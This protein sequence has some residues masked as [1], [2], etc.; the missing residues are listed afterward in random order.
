[1]LKET[2][3]YNKSG[4]KKKKERKK[5]EYVHVRKMVVFHCDEFFTSIFVV[6]CC[7]CFYN[8]KYGGNFARPVE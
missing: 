1:M 2:E 3:N 8:A 5:E 7:Y 6:V 4:G